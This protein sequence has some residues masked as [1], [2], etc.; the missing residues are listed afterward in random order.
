MWCVCS[1]NAMP[2]LCVFIWHILEGICVWYLYCMVV[3]VRCT[4]VFLCSTCVVNVWCG[5][6]GMEW[7]MHKWYVCVCA[8]V[9]YDFIWIKGGWW[10]L[11]VW[12][13]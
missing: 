12:C 8:C 2:L 9:C 7:T 1:E 11:Y 6:I 4:C 5:G 13:M 10:L 3:S